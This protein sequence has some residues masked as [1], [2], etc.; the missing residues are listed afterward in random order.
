MFNASTVF[1]DF[2]TGV[3]NVISDLTAHK[4]DNEAHDINSLKNIS[5]TTY[6]KY[7]DGTMFVWGQFTLDTS[8]IGN[9]THVFT[10]PVEF[11][12]LAPYIF[13]S[14]GYSAS[15]Q[16][17]R[18]GNIAARRRADLNLTDVEIYYQVI[19]TVGNVMRGHVFA[20]GRWKE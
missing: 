18:V 10:Y 6:V 5:D 19:N 17:D 13:V 7:P 12:G 4:A 15:S 3:N 8:S 9:K 2:V 16:H 14:F 1:S 11:V 20:V